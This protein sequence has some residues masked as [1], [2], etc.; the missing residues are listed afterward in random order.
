MVAQAFLRRYCEAA[1]GVISLDVP[2]PGLE[3]WKK[4]TSDPLQW[5]IG[6]RQMPGL[7]EK[8]VAGRQAIYFKGGFFNR[9]TVNKSAI[10]D[11]DVRHYVAPR[12]LRIV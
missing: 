7:A 3:P 10:T 4:V 9:G 6:F 5:H 11:A 12:G 1:R 2:L 8:I